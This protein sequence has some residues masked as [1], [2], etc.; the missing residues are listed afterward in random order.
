MSFFSFLDSDVIFLY[1]LVSFIW[2]FFRFNGIYS[3]MIF[4]YHS[5]HWSYLGKLMNLSTAVLVPSCMICISSIE[6]FACMG[7]CCL[8]PSRCLFDYK[9]HH[10]Y[11]ENVWGCY[12]FLWRQL[13]LVSIFG[14]L[15]Q[16]MLPRYDQRP[17]NRYCIFVVLYFIYIYIGKM[18]FSITCFWNFIFAREYMYIKKE[19]RLKTQE[20]RTK[21]IEAIFK[22]TRNAFRQ[23]TTLRENWTR[24]FKFS[25]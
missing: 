12:T 3:G 6:N 7:R 22:P 16:T 19:N 13:Y 9:Q 25:P 2:R 11:V 23:T 8:C 4:L 24:H 21:V 14:L 5:Q 1:T 17:K 10:P 20:N 15:L 18:Y